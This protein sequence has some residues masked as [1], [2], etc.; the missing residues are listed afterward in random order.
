MLRFLCVLLLFSIRFH[1]YG[2]VMFGLNAGLNNTLMTNDF[3]DISDGPFVG[4][5]VAAEASLALGKK[6]SVEFQS[7][8]IKKGGV[9][10][11]WYSDPRDMHHY[12]LH[13]FQNTVGAAF[14]P[15]KNWFV[16]VAGYYSRLFDGI[17]KENRQVGL[18]STIPQPFIP[19]NYYPPGIEVY[20]EYSFSEMDFPRNEYG[21]MFSIGFRSDNGV[22]LAVN[23]SASWPWLEFQNASSAYTSFRSLSTAFTFG[24]SFIKKSKS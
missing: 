13:Y 4:P 15:T 19:S 9:L 17:E 5:S 8:Y 14:Y 23:V 24:Y 7:G 22:K 10:R 18:Y 6:W 21:A 16:K 3:F 2:Q 11:K 1:S 20:N 12:K